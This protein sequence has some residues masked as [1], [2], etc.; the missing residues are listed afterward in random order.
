MSAINR[1]VILNPTRAALMRSTSIA[2]TVAFLALATGAAA[3][4]INWD[5]N[6]AAGTQGSGNGNWNT[7][8]Q[9]WSLNA[10]AGAGLSDQVFANGRNVTFGPVDN[11]TVTIDA[12]PVSPA[13]IIFSGDGYV[14]AG[15][16]ANSLDVT[17]TMNITVSSTGDTAQITAPLTMSTGETITF[18]GASDGTLRISGGINPG[19]AL[20]GTFNA[21]G[22]TLTI[23][24]DAAINA[25]VVN[26]GSTTTSG[27]DIGGD[28]TVSGGNFTHNTAGSVTG[29]TTVSSGTLTA[30][31]GDFGATGVTLNGGNLTYTG[32]S[33][34]NVTGNGGILT[35]NG[36]GILRGDLTNDGSTTTNNGQ[37]TGTVD[38]LDGTVNNAGAGVIGGP[39][40]VNGAGAV[41][42]ANGG[43]FT[44]GVTLTNGTV[45]YTG[46]SSGNVTA[47]GGDLNVNNGGTLA[48]TLG[49]SGTA[50]VDNNGTG[51]ITGLTTIS[52][53][54]VNG[55]GGDFS[56][57]IT[58]TAGDLNYTGDSAGNVTASGGTIDVS[59]TGILRGTLDNA[60]AATV[61]AA[62]GR[63]TGSTTLS[64]GSINNAG[65]IDDNVAVSGGTLTNTNDI[66]GTVGITGTGIVNNNGA[67]ASITGLVTV[68]SAT[69]TLNANGG[70]F[71]GG[72]S[73]IAGDVNYTGDSAGNV[74]AT[75]GTI[76][77]SGTGILRGTLSNGGTAITTIAAG[78]QVTGATTISGGS[79]DNGGTIG[80]TVLVNG[81]GTLNNNG[82]GVITGLT[83]VNA[84][85]ATVNANGGDF[86]GGLTL[87]NGD[88]NYTGD[89]A[90]NV[91]ANG[92]TLD[93]SGTGILRGTLNN[94]G[95]T[96]VIASGGQVTGATTVSGGSVSNDGTIDDNVSV[97]STGV[98]TNTGSITGTVGISG[99]GI[100]NNNTTGDIA[101]VV[102]V[103]GGTLN[104]NG[105]TFSAPGNGI[106][107]AGGAVSILADTDVDIGH[108][109]G[110][111]IIAATA[112]PGPTLTGTI[113][114][115]GGGTVTN[116]GGVSGNVSVNGGTF[117][118]NE[119]IGGTLTMGGAGGSF[120]NNPG[121]SITGLATVNN[122]TLAAN[123]GTFTAG[124][125]ANGGNVDINA[126]T[127]ANI[128]VDGGDLDIAS[129]IALTGTVAQTTGSTTNN[130]TVSGNVSV[131]GGTFE[132]DDTD[133]ADAVVA[134]IGGTLTISGGSF[135][136]ESGANVAGAVVV[137]E[138][139]I[140]S[141]TL[142][143]N[144]G[145][146]GTSPVTN[147]GG[148]INVNA[149]TTANVANN[150]GTLDIDAGDT[151]TGN[152]TNGETVELNGTIAGT[153][154][155]SGDVN[156]AN[157][158]A[159]TGAV[160][161]ASGG[162][163]TIADGGTATFGAGI[164][165]FGG[166]TITVG[167]GSTLSSVGNLVDNRAGAILNNNG[168]VDA[169]VSNLG[170]VNATNA[171]FNGVVGNS[172]IINATDTTFNAFVGSSGTI[173]GTGNLTFGAGLNSSGTISTVNS[174]ANDVITLGA[175]SNLNGTILRFD[176]DL[177]PPSGTVGASDTLVITGG[178]AT[179]NVTLA[180]NSLGAGSVDLDDLLIIDAN[181]GVNN[182][183]V[184]TPTFAPPLTGGSFVYFLVQPGGVGTDVFLRNQ[185]NP[186]IT[187]LAGNVTLTQSLIGS[188]INRPSSPFV[189]GLAYDDPDQCG[190]G[191]WGRAIAG[192]AD[193]TG[194][195]TADAGLA[196]EETT[197]SSL[198][199]T[200]AGVQFGGDFA[201][202]N[203]YLNGWDVA[204][205][206]IG[207]INLGSVDQPVTVPGVGLGDPAI[208]TS[209]T[210]ADFLQ[211]YAGVY[212]TASRGPLAFDLQY[213]LEK[214]DFTVNNSSVGG[215][216][217]LGITD[218]DFSSKA[219][220][221]SGSASYG[222]PIGD[223]N[224]AVVPTVGF[225]WTRTKTD[226]IV[227]DNGDRLLIDD[228]DSQTIFVGATVARTIF[229]ESGDSLQRQFITAS[230]YNDF[231]DDPTARFDTGGPIVG[232]LVNENLGAYTELSA[233]WNYVRILNPG[234]IGPA[235]QLDASIRADARIGDQLN[236]YG[237]T[238]Q[239][240]LQF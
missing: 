112:A 175:D 166:A 235:R 122:G 208:V 137:S 59:G 56:G 32:D 83:T 189:S 142:N 156:A 107:N 223:S 6:A 25:D 31:G 3:Q 17:G 180:F 182:L 51:N 126:A 151:L 26:S 238:G 203:G 140:T 204:A 27:G 86:N 149:D 179:G 170:T 237:I 168:T 119:N 82:A 202:F 213:R 93:I 54:V 134:G 155:N 96:T 79:V 30:A 183:N 62:G 169:I 139:A 125:D 164:T 63:V 236:S 178:T 22:E 163:I 41:L 209:I 94:G 50:N 108:T 158:S 101:G 198:S 205:G 47:T 233:G 7:T 14:I 133:A 225:A 105:G 100:V 146:F 80:G 102:T 69:A 174:A 218:R 88:V 136:N 160:N 53:G 210:N 114:Q 87:T 91:T 42:N 171:T 28:L 187:A 231:A 34:G 95:A 199:A 57:G 135:D 9:N 128:T 5:T 104:A 117:N 148:T 121:G 157:G 143:M 64:S 194:N 36:S 38:V 44:G 159:V 220:T 65:T 240:R 43:D 68:N 45:N 13:S 230:Y 115:S 49:V 40:T 232:N 191:L 48:G 154:G 73:L 181:G 113:S 228:F 195:S 162:D 84:A 150:S 85:G 123:G 214:T 172:G 16:G 90:G 132:N 23:D 106:V 111:T 197:G 185:V 92:G 21:A 186:G 234:Q 2:A 81:T 224:F 188:I 78:G 152:V 217:S 1:K 11:A 46:N 71:T 12:G 229:S 141:G 192:K 72:V 153:L 184:G 37:I 97:S 127:T 120:N 74:T 173:N 161:N 116:N 58:M 15:A 75:G 138:T 118:N 109:G 211:Y 222:I 201:C 193:A 76:D 4:D 227:F 8:D 176:I 167:T 33:T 67:G 10:G 216:A 103:N 144:G 221:L 177:D 239:L 61:I 190:A 196:S 89:S 147:N 24:N 226:P 207:G 131:S 52:G 20:G 206:G 212:A 35:V 215:G 165:N 19:G 145:T 130:G 55:N 99:T 18:T 70:D 77:V 98:L 110:N 60:G 66:T 124:I 39:T 219:Q 29:D 129:G 200:Y